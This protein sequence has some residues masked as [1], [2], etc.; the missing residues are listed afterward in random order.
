MIPLDLREK[1]HRSVSL[2]V[3]HLLDVSTVLFLVPAAVAVIA[4]LCKLQDSMTHFGQEVRGSYLAGATADVAGLDVT[5]RF[6]TTK[7]PQGLVLCGF[8]RVIGVLLDFL[9][10]PGTGIEPVQPFQ[11]D[12][13]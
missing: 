12:G 2:N 13:F 9:V 8:Y 11:A 3:K 1:P 10:V 7:N 5:K 6:R 4:V